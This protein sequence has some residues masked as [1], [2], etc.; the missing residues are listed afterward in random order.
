MFTMPAELN[1]FP[2]SEE[3][4]A[5][6][7]PMDI[8]LGQATYKFKP[9]GHRSGRVWRATLVTIIQEIGSKFAEEVTTNGGFLHGLAYVFLNVPEKMVEVVRSFNPDLPWDKILDDDAVTDEQIAL[10]F[11]K[12]LSLGFPFVQQLALMNQVQTVVGAFPR[13]ARSGS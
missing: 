1:R 7:T 11:S 6:S 5:L 4:C 3:D 2:R 13:S 8:Q 12:V 10:A 9:L